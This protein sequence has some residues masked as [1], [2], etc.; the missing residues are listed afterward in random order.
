MNWLF[1]WS[2]LDW[3][4]CLW[5]AVTVLGKPQL[6][7]SA[8]SCVLALIF[9]SQTKVEKHPENASSFNVLAQNW[10]SSLPYSIVQVSQNLAQ[11]SSHVLFMI[12]T[13]TLI[14]T[15]PLSSVITSASGYILYHFHLPKSNP[16]MVPPVL[17]SLPL[18]SPSHISTL[19]SHPHLTHLP[20]G[21]E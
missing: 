19:C 2:H 13:L 15:P 7:N 11:F 8:L 4:V 3:F 14:L 20:W 6:D 10:H 12:S 9:L 1:S 21:E 16:N 18:V 17:L 5:S